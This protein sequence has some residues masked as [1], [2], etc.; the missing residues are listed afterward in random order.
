M[1]AAAYL[2]MCSV[3][4]CDSAKRVGRHLEGYGP[5][6]KRLPKRMFGTSWRLTPVALERAKAWRELHETRD[7]FTDVDLLV[8]IILKTAA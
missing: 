4:A 3:D 8:D 1:I 6:A 7:N 2:A 5:D